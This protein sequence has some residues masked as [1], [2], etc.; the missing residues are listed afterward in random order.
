MIQSSKK[1]S[2]TWRV[3]ILASGYQFTSSEVP[4]QP[5]FRATGRCAMVPWWNRLKKMQWKQREA[6]GEMESPRNRWDMSF[7]VSWIWDDL[8]VFDYGLCVLVSTL[9]IILLW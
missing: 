9:V 4:P 3:W 2:A 8:S 5:E 7:R 6:G 1:E